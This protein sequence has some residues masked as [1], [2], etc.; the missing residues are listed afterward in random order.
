MLGRREFLGLALAAQATPASQAAESRNRQAGLG[1]RRLGRTNYLISEIVMG[2][3]SISATRC[4]HVLMALDQGLNYLD[5]APAYGDGASELGYRKIIQSRGRDKF[6]LNSKVSLWDINRHRLYQDI[7]ASLGEPE[8]RRLRGLALEEIARRQ[9]D[10]PDY[11]V[12]YFNGQRG[13][14]DAA[15]LADVMERQYGDRIDRAKNFKQLILESVDASLRRL[16]TD[17]LDL[18]MCPHGA[19]TPQE[20]L[21]YPEVFDAFEQLKKAGK[22]RH[23]GVSAHNDPAGVLE[24][25]VK[26]GVYSAAMIAYNIVNAPRV[27][28]AVAAAKKADLGVIAMKV[29]RAVHMGRGRP[30]S[31]ERIAKIEAAVPGPLKAPQKAYVWALRNP[32]LTA[33]VSEMTSAEHVTDNL[34]L[35]R[36]A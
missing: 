21:R 14:L 30:T 27:E 19:T 3:N 32:H 12:N 13:E 2:G 22:V 28:P 31:P 10:A 20:L 7:F 9:T 6:F 16:G 1:Y 34:P 24:A 36:K 18:L 29:A 11:F 25:A 15:A 8:Q 35:A 5:T 26:S 17:H 33:C 4:D 23:L